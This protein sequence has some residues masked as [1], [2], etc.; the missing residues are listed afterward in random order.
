MLLIPTMKTHLVC[1]V[2]IRDDRRAGLLVCV[3]SCN[4]WGVF[5]DVKPPITNLIAHYF[6]RDLFLFTTKVSWTDNSAI[7]GGLVWYVWRF[8]RVPMRPVGAQFLT[9][10][11]P[12]DFPLAIVSNQNQ[13][14]L[15]LSPRFS[16]N[17]RTLVLMNEAYEFLLLHITTRKIR[18]LT[19][20]Y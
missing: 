12:L 17:P 8:L 18:V 14:H 10:P 1:Y 20:Y 13:P 9:S 16:A 15:P 3:W 5:R 11:I 4:A 7:I 19:R 2:L 6:S